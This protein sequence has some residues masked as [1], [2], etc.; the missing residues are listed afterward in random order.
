MDMFAGILP[1]IQELPN[2]HPMLVHFPIALLCG[3]LAMEL[4]GAITDKDS[5]RNAATWM[6]YLGTAGAIITVISGYSAAGGVEHGKVVHELMS[7]HAT[8]GVI[9]AV[10][11]VILS[12]WRLTVG[13]RF[14]SFWRTVHFAVGIV[15]VAAIFFGA[16]K[17]GLM[18]FKHGVGVQTTQ[19]TD[20]AQSGAS[21]FDHH[22]G[23]GGSSSGGGHGH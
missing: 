20:A 14:S 12:V 5:I 1:G 3:F 23:G 17:G 22:K 9:I 6:L 19:S 4:L 2:I 16:D 11:A 21:A 13:G 15:M 8:T 7:C 10:L 18:V